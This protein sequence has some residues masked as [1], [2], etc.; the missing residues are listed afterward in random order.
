MPDTA[1]DDLP[2][3]CNL[4][5]HFKC[6]YVTG[7]ETLEDGFEGKFTRHWWRMSYIGEACQRRYGKNFSY[8]F[9]AFFAIPHYSAIAIGNTGAALLSPFVDTENE[10]RQRAKRSSNSGGDKVDGPEGEHLIQ[11]DSE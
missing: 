5:E 11:S 2:D 3:A 4:I 1:R 9:E 8:V 10:K 7:K 6:V